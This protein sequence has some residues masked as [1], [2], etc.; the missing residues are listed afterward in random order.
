MLNTALTVA[1]VVGE[2]GCVFSCWEYPL[3][4]VW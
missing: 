1:V 3:C 2:V 4:S